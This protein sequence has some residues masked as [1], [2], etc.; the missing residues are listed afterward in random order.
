LY[1]KKGETLRRR[2][3]KINPKDIGL[4]TEFELLLRFVK[5]DPFLSIF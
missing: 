3:S 2:S 1:R 5:I 4:D